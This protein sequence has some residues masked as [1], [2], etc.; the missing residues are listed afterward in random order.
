MQLKRSMVCSYSWGS[1]SSI[2][3]FELKRRVEKKSWTTLSFLYGKNSLVCSKY[4]ISA[5]TVAHAF[6]YDVHK[7]LAL[8]L[9]FLSREQSAL[10]GGDAA[11]DALRHD[12]DR[13]RLGRLRATHPFALA[14]PYVLLAVFRPLY[15]AEAYKEIGVRSCL[16]RQSISPVF[17]QPS[18]FN[19][20]H[21]EAIYLICFS[22]RQTKEIKN[23]SFSQGSVRRALFIIKKH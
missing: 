18:F 2:R 20:S 5:D 4:P 7:N 13:E 6:Q 3:R 16:F 10:V 11:V 19:V 22:M 1:L 15:H 9:F 21:P 17:Y 23:S 12:G 8:S 14:F